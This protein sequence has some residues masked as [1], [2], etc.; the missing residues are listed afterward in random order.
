[1]VWVIGNFVALFLGET[2]SPR[3]ISGKLEI[4]PRLLVSMNLRPTVIGL[5]DTLTALIKSII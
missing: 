4:V 5:I 3:T 2:A 1:M